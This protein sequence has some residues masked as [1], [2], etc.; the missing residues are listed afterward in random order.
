MAYD[1]TAAAL[2]AKQAS[3]AAS[4]LSTKEKNDALT[5]ISRILV[6]QADSVLEANAIDLAQAKENG[7]PVVMQ[8]RLL[9]TRERV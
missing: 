1:I 3:Q 6:Q 8:D 7:M 2:A 5:A 4:L 9:L